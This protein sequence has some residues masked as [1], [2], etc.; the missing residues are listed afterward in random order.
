MLGLCIGCALLIFE[1]HHDYA[2]QIILL[3]KVIP[4]TRKHCFPS[5]EPSVIQQSRKGRNLRFGILMLFDEAMRTSEMT[6]MSVL[7]KQRYAAKHGYELVVAGSEPGD[8]NPARPPAWSK[9]LAMRRHLPRFDFLL[10]TD[11]DTLVM[12]FD[13]T[14]DEMVARSGEESSSDLIFTEDWNGL[15]SGVFM[16]RNSSWTHWFLEEA[17]GTAGSEQEYMA[18]HEISEQGKKYPFEYEQRSL[19]YLLQTR[20]WTARGLPQYSP[21][22]PPPPPPPH[23]SM[24]TEL[25][26][27]AL[28]RSK[29]STDTA[30]NSRFLRHADDR[31]LASGATDGDLWNHVS[32]LPQCALNSYMLYPRL[33]SLFS[34]PPPQYVASQWVP[35]DFIV[36][37]AGHKGSNKADLFRYCFELSQQT[38]RIRK[39]RR[40]AFQSD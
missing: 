31:I 35:G 12:N 20:V 27:S 28:R 23:R 3:L 6:R 19:H 11:V 24:S 40:R 21:S 4:P 33:S 5:I 37:M 13:V 9:L 22:R 25:E 36:H 32:L 17:W 26:T 8:I 29:N 7:N 2:W 38:S 39:G 34:S 30:K 1:L 14:L 10:F 15:N 18:L 16:L